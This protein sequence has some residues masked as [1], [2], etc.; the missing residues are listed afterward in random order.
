MG[1]WRE[2]KFGLFIHWGIYS[3][4]A[5]RWQ[6]KQVEGIGEWIMNNA[7]IPVDEY[8][9]FSSRFNPV[10]YDADAWVR[11]A[12]DAGMK[13]IV[14]T[15]KHHDGFAMFHSKAS[16]YN[17]VD[18]TEFKRDPLAELAEACKKH[19]LRLGFYYSQAQDW[20]HPGG[21]KYRK[22]WDPKQEGSMDDYI[23]DVAVPQVKEIL[24]NYGPIA[25]LWWDTPADMT[26]ERA[27]KFLPLF[28]L[29]P[30]LITNDRLGGGFPGDTG[31][32]EQEI[33]ATGTPGRDWETCMTMN[34]TW[35]FKVD[36]HN[37]KSVEILLRNLVDI[38]S[39]GGNYLLNVGPTSEGVI[40]DESVTRLKAVGA[41]LAANGESIYGTTASPF[42]R[43][44][45]GR[46]TA[47]PGK[48]Y[49]H[50]F[51]WPSDG[52]LRVP[53]LKNPVK[54]AKLL[55]GGVLEAKNDGDDVLISVPEKAPDPLDTV[56]VVE[57]EGAPEVV[58]TFV[59]KPD[60]M[61]IL[62][63]NAAD[64]DIHGTSARYEHGDGK[65]NIGF[66]TNK[67][68]WL[69]WDVILEK[70]GNLAVEVVY[71]AEKGSG[72][73]EYLVTV[74][75]RSLPGRVADTGSWTTF[76]TRSLGKIRITKPGKYTVTV[77]PVT[78]KT[79]AVMNLKAVVLK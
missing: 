54:S 21:G 69:S 18:A 40:P 5:G 72:G 8:A 73:S 25:I 4:P 52:K 64:A 29:Q 7:P 47:K 56:L 19:G 61:G 62:R 30:G 78:M 35:G 57:I 70:V 20:H 26:K 51:E 60:G 77:K 49:L 2:A 66:W 13:Y 42:K 44:A 1:W 79:Y 53:G 63:L 58:N 39:K 45:W 33:P 55:A 14:I 6:D 27:E 65:D 36:D 12:K 10:K 32:P 38:V 59:V 3:V 23:R 11:M 50:V 67:E 9:A 43:L 28:D 37:W 41:W 71:A 68:D 31:T 74:G 75:E 22:N 15:S 48:L 17:V 46:C 76:I 16:P 34:D 24:T